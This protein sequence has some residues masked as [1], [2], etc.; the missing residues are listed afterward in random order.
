MLSFAF[1]SVPR[2]IFGGLFLAAAML[3]LTSCGESSSSG[4]NSEK[5]LEYKL[6]YLD[7]G[8]GAAEDQA[9]TARYRQALNKLTARFGISDG[10]VAD[11]TR[12]V[13]KK[14]EGKTTM[15]QLMEAAIATSRGSAGQALVMNNKEGYASILA[16][17]AAQEN[18]KSSH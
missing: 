2:S 17:L 4:A 16:F 6:A 5:P 12:F 14:I 10:E 1:T 15:L 7:S 9:T 11:M 3:L 8:S 13:A 18:G